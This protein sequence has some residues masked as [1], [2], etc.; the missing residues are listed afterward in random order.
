MRSQYRLAIIVV[1]LEIK[2]FGAGREQG[3]W[4]SLGYWSSAHESVTDFKMKL[5]FLKGIR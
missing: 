3:F 1:T 5:Q 2:R 4:N